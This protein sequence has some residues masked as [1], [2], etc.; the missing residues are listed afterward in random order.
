MINYDIIEASIRY[1]ADKGFVR[2]ETPWVV[3]KAITDIT[4]PPFAK[5]FRLHNSEDVLVASGEQS[6]LYQYR[7]GYIPKGRYQTVTPCWRD[8]DI[9]LTHSKWF[10]KNE[11]IITDRVSKAMLDE[12]VQHA[13]TFF[14]SY[15]IE[16]NV[17]KTEDGTSNYS[18]DIN[19][20]D[21]ELGSYGI[22]NHDT[23]LWIYGTGVAEPRFSS[24]LTKERQIWVTIP[25][26]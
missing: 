1:Y 5:D 13:A 9:T 24:T 17:F 10:L 11:L 20:G 14:K 23:L 15:G 25:E 2:L 12:V 22:R 8:E 18:F 21:I 6:F 3:P 26:K 19:C 4:K 16:V 7:M